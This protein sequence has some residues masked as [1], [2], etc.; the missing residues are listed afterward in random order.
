[1]EQTEEDLMLAELV[2]IVLSACQILFFV[3]DTPP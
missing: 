3:C 2:S 1:M